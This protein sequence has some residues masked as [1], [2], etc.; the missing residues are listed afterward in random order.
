MTLNTALLKALTVLET[1]TI[2]Q[3]MEAIDRGAKQIALVVGEQGQLRATITDGDVRRGHLRGVALDATVTEI[4]QTGFTAVSEEEGHS[5]AMRHMRAH[6]LHQIPIIDATGRLVDLAVIDEKP[7]TTE[8]NVRVILMAG[9]LGTRLRPLTETIPKPMLPIGGKPILE[10]IL[11]NLIDQG[12]NKFTLSLNYRGEMIRE[13]F[14]D[15]ADI[16]AEIDYLVEAK[17]MGTAGALS[18]I[19]TRPEQ[20]FIVMNG[21]LITS[22]PFDALLRFHAETGA[23][24]TMCARDYQIMVP[25]GVIEVEDTSLRRIVEKPTYSHFVNAGIY[26]LSPDALNHVEPDEYLDMPTLFERIVAKGGGASVFPMQEYWIDIGRHEDL[27]RARNE[28]EGLYG[29]VD[30]QSCADIQ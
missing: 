16:G 25:Y 24:A 2:R 14:G 18:L 26:V 21:D 30:D 11:R 19:K 8:R 12:Y 22:I 23:V 3:A 5:A 9:G 13:Y 27:E 28:F 4:M 29:E 7:D 15:G 17:R 10:L 6:G 20:P 1:A